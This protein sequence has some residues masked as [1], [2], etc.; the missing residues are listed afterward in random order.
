MRIFLLFGV[1][2]QALALQ[3]QVAGNDSNCSY[4]HKATEGVSYYRQLSNATSSCYLDINPQYS[5]DLVYRSYLLS[6]Q[7]LFM[8]FNSYGQGD[9][10]DK[11][12][13]RVYYFFPRQ[14][15]PNA[16][17]GNDKVIFSTATPGTEIS[18]DALSAKFSGISS[19]LGVGK[20]REDSNIN[21]NNNGG[22][23]IFDY[24]GLMLDLGFSLGADP[25]S[26]RNGVATFT[27]QKGQIC[28]V[29]NYEIFKY[30]STGDVQFKYSDQELKAFL[31]TSCVHLDAGY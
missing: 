15:M 13:A 11:T 12:G 10:S 8:V 5:A 27:D 6:N 4:W 7:G 31:K 26:N 9:G 28:R 2:L 19:H 3:A 23:E 24:P 18:L 17:T 16:K 22:L 20:F 25:A 14:Q 1:F 30:A 21:E 29:K